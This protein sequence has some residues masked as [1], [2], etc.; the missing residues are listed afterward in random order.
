MHRIR[1]LVARSQDALTNPGLIPENWARFARY[2]QSIKY[3]GPI[4][5][6]SDCTKVKRTLSYSTDYGG[7]VLGTV[8]DLADVEVDGPDDIDEIVDRANK[9]NAYASQAR[10]VLARVST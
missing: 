2:T 6:A 3:D 10:A 1:S 9:Q 8:F 4:I 5:V 7:H